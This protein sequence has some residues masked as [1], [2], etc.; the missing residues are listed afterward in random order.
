[1]QKKKNGQFVKITENRQSSRTCWAQNVVYGVLKRAEC[2]YHREI[3]VDT[4][5]EQMHQI[6]DL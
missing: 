4:I 1:M 3:V 5:F 6:T 2:K